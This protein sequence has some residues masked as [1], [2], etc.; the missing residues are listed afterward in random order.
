MLGLGIL[1]RVSD[2]KRQE[3]LQSLSA[4]YAE[5]AIKPSRRF[6]VQDVHDDNLVGW[7]GY[8]RTEEQLAGFIASPTFQTLKGAIDTLGRLEQLQKLTLEALPPSRLL[9]TQRDMERE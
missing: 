5:P 2:D 6:V 8:W 1:T 4:F 9:R 3:L 7:L